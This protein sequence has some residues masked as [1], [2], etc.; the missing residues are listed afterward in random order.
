[1]IELKKFNYIN[2]YNKANTTFQV[3]EWE[4]MYRFLFKVFSTQIENNMTNEIIFKAYL[5]KM[6]PNYLAN[7]SIARKVIDY[8]AGMTDNYFLSEYEKYKD[9]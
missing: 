4:K 6:D 7:T 8:M 5:N 3:K 2:I 9:A 1:M